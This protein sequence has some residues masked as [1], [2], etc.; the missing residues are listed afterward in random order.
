MANITVGMVHVDWGGGI[1]HEADALANELGKDIE[2]KQFPITS[3]DS[4]NPY[5]WYKF[6]RQVSS[7]CDIVHVQYNATSFG[8]FSMRVPTLGNGINI[9]LSG[10][11]FPVFVRALDVPL[12]STVHGAG[13]IRQSDVS[14]TSSTSLLHFIYNYISGFPGRELLS[15]SD[16]LLPLGVDGKRALKERGIEESK[17][18]RI[19]IAYSDRLT[20][21]NQEECKEQLELTNKTVL[22]CFGWIRPSKDYESVIRALVELPEDTV[23]LVAGGVYEGYETYRNEIDELVSKLG[24]QDR[25]HFT[26]YVEKSK[27]PVIFGATDILILPYEDDRPS[28]VLAKGLAY[29]LPIITSDQPEFRDVQER[30]DCIEIY[31]DGELTDT[32]SNLV[33]DKDRQRELKINAQEYSKEINIRET[34]S[35]L[36]EIYESLV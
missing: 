7:E 13:V 21:P 33:T 31:R 15:Q 9:N 34:S 35:R 28:D 16:F 2:V 30:F 12:V 29:H 18:E 19:P 22:T 25:V 32:L 23:F 11:M 20:L 8:S 3:H 24:L 4:L 5:N 27:H 26:G 6:G 14:L 17:L 10:I 36:L 1:A